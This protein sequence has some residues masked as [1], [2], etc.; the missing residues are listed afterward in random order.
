MANDPVITNTPFVLFAADGYTLLAMTRVKQYPGREG[1]R[2]SQRFTSVRL[3]SSAIEGDNFLTP[4][5]EI[6][7]NGEEQL[8][9]LRLAIDLALEE[10]SRG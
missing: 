9:T 10:A 7:V 4:A 5:A 1:Y 3:F 6:V 8:R 2:P